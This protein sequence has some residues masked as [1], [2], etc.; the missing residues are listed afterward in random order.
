MRGELKSGLWLVVAACAAMLVSPAVA[1]ARPGRPLQHPGA[2]TLS[3]SCKVPRTEII[4]TD[5][6]FDGNATDWADIP[7]AAV[8]FVSKRSGCVVITFS[9]VA[10][11]DNEELYVQ[12]VLDG[13][14]PCSPAYGFEAASAFAAPTATFNAHSA[15]Y[16]CNDVTPGAH[17]V[18]AQYTTPA[19]G[20]VTLYSHTLAVDH[21]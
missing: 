13:T 15:T 19:G 20:L 18:Q 3:G 17:S 6:E 1:D 7:D 10:Y 5:K 21:N 2:I 11:S 14:S 9:G 8:N 16:F 4:T 12:M